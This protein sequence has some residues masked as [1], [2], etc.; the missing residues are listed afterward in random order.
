MSSPSI[1]PADELRLGRRGARAPSQR[2][3]KLSHFK[4]GVFSEITEEVSLRQ[5]GSEEALQGS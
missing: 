4:K 1:T 5:P 2:V 3:G